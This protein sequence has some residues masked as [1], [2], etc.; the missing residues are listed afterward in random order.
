MGKGKHM[1][2]V[3]ETVF[4]KVFSITMAA[5]TMGCVVACGFGFAYMVK[6]LG[7]I[8]RADVIRRGMIMTGGV[9]A[10]AT[11]LISILA[12][13]ALLSITNDISAMY[14]CLLALLLELMIGFQ[15]EY[16]LCRKLY[17]EVKEARIIA[18]YTSLIASIP[19]IFLFF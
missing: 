10:F 7:I 19:V 6:K 3:I 11:M 16:Y 15:L 9:L 5:M 1:T 18:I 4:W 17:F 13:L 14:I 8:R 2:L 12:L